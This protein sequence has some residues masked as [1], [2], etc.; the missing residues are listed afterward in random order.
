VANLSGLGVAEVSAYR[1]YV[2]AKDGHFA[3]FRAFACDGDADATAWAKQLVDGNDI[4]LWS[5]DRL[6]TRLNSIGKPGAVTHEVRDGRMI[7]KPAK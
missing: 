3:S 7:P 4:E 1:A 5:G 2:I 6:V